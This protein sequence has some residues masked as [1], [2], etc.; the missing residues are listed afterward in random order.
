M[1][2]KICRGVILFMLGAM[3]Y[4]FIGEALEVYGSRSA[5]NIGGEVLIL[6]LMAGLVWLGWELCRNYHK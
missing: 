2:H 1:R 6:P 5:G 4:G 3:T